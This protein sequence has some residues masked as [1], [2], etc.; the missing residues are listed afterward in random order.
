MALRSRKRPPLGSPRP[1]QFAVEFEAMLPAMPIAVHGHR[2]ARALFPENTIPAFLFAIEAGADFVELDTWVTKDDVLVVSHDPILKRRLCKG[3][4]GTRIVREQSIEQ[5]RLWDCGSRKNRRFPRQVAVPGA[6]IPTLDEVFA[7]AEGSAI[8][9]NIEVKSI[10]DLP[11]LAPEPEP[12]AA[13]LV[14]AI[15]RRKLVPRV[16]VQ[17]FDLRILGAVRRICPEVRLSALSKLD[18]RSF[19]M[20]AQ[21]A[22][23]GIVGPYHRLVTQH[24]VSAAHAAGIQV[25]PWTA[26]RPRDWRR[27][28][29]A[30]VDGI[31]TDDPAGLIAYLRARGLRE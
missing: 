16:I 23:T 9:F 27:L 7:L 26:N 2:G 6:G 17:S 14:Q 18:A 11:A 29:R 12:Y 5:L 22:G 30:G 20:L 13:L 31:I 21:R 8:Q 10:R 15:E 1:T 25:I 24:R 28:I 3:S 4:R 19:A